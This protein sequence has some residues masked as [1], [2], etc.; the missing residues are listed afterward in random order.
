MCIRIVNL[1]VKRI[2]GCIYEFHCKFRII[3]EVF[4]LEIAFIDFMIIKVKGIFRIY[5]QFTDHAGSVS[6]RFQTVYQIGR[7]RIVHRIFPCCQSYL[8]VLVGIKT[9]QKACSGRRASGLR[10]IGVFKQ[11]AF[12]CKPV[13]VRGFYRS[14]IASYFSA[15]VF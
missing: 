5:M 13:E 3:F 1:Q 2:F 7:F 8:S 12:L 15:I 10:H 6:C 14:T 4:S 11:S 9:C